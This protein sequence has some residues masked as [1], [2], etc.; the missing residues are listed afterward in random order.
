MTQNVKCALF[1][2]FVMADAHIKGYKIYITIKNITYAAIVKT[3]YS[4]F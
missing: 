3:G 2:L 4:N 1:S